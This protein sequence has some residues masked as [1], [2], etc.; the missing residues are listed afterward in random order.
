ML[1]VMRVESEPELGL[2]MDQ[3]KKIE[4]IETIVQHRRLADG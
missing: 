3:I 1:K 4:S 2:P